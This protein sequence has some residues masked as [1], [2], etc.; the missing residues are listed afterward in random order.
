MVA[1]RQRQVHEARERDEIE[2]LHRRF[3]GHQQARRAVGHLTDIIGGIY[4]A[5]LYQSVRIVAPRSGEVEFN[6]PAP[7]RA[8]AG[9]AQRLE[10]V[11]LGHGDQTS[12]KLAARLP[13]KAARPSFASA[14]PAAAVI[15]R[16]SRS[17]W[18]SKAPSKLWRS[19]ARDAPNAAV[20]ASAR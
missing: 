6:Q 19:S 17:S 2:A 20:G 18:V 15:E 5:A 11:G 3:A 12:L 8:T 9:D 13:K 7:A 16:S 10:D 1:R 14:A 4:P